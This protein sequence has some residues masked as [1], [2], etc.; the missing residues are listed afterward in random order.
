MVI[1]GRCWYTSAQ[2]TFSAYCGIRA[3]TS[4]NQLMCIGVG[5]P[6]GVSTNGSLGVTRQT[7]ARSAG[8]CSSAASHWIRPP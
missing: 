1:S 8:G 7:I 3:S 5:T 2:L 6:V 4:R